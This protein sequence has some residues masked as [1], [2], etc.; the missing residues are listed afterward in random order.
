[1]NALA[2]ALARAIPLLV[3]PRVI[4]LVLLPLVA[5]VA[6]VSGLAVVFWTPL[7]TAFSTALAN[8]LAA[9]GAAWAPLTWLV[10]AVGGVAAF[11]LLL[12]VAGVLVLASIAVLAGPV[13]T[14]VVAAHYFPALERKRGGTLW[15]GAVNAL[16]ATAVWLPLWLLT[17]PFLLLPIVGIP[18]SLLLAA[19][20]GQRLFRYDALADHASAEERV[21]IL[22]GARGR[23]LALGLMLAPL[24][25]L[26]FVN[27]MAPVYAGLAFTCLCLDELAALRLR[28]PLAD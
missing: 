16:G 14:R 5:A 21:R 10:A 2:R 3:D 26:P 18:L 1:M 4:G 20:L 13:F 22:R 15:G 19:W 23:L 12:L 11:L 27:L 17:L 8:A 24:S 6:L 25:L 9:V 7:Q 28:A